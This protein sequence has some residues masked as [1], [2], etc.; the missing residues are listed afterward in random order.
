MQVRVSVMITLA[1]IVSLLAGCSPAAPTSVPTKAAIASPTTASPAQAPAA[2]K[3]AAPTPTA[4]AKIKRGGILR[5]AG[6][7]GPDSPDPHL[8]AG[9]ATTTFPIIFDGL[10]RY[11]MDS[12][13]GFLVP[14]PEMVESWEFPNPT[15]AIFKVRQGI[16]FHDGSTWDA[17]VLRWNLDRIMNHKKSRGKTYTEAIKS[18]E[19]VD[20]RTVKLTLKAPSA[21]LLVNLSRI[22]TSTHMVSKEAVEKMGDDAFLRKP[23][24]SGPFE[25]VEYIENFRFTAKRFD[26]YWEK[27]ADGQNLPYLDGVDFRVILD[28]AVAVMELKARTIDLMSPFEPKDVTTIRADPELTYTELNYALRTV[29]A[30]G[31]NQFKGFI[32]AAEA[33]DLVHSRVEGLI[34]SVR[35]VLQEEPTK[36][37]LS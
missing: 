29:P 8:G 26:R 15:T 14:K 31:F 37:P 10:F 18:V 34:H 11:E 7:G 25:L 22:S 5:P 23:V 9:G 32:Q 12:Q 30:V 4:V 24:G 21:A 33:R 6:E 13:A 16:V 20:P 3:P 27:G 19:L 28:T 2:A 35:R 36:S 17:E 1:M